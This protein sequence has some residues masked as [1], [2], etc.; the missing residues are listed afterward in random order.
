MS[1]STLTIRYRGWA[2]VRL[3]TDPDPADE[4]YG[5]SG[6]TYAYAGEP[7]L[8]RITRFQPAPQF[9]RPGPGYGEHERWPWGVEVFDAFTLANGQK[10][11][12]T[13][14]IGEPVDMLDDPVLENRNWLLT[15]PGWEP[16]VPF[17]LRIGAGEQ[18]IE[19]DAPIVKGDDRPAWQLPTRLL[20]TQAARGV[21][22][23]R[24]AI[25]TATGIWD[26][27]Q[28]Y[29]D[30][31]AWLEQAIARETDPLKRQVLCSRKRQVETDLANPAEAIGTHYAI[32]SFDFPVNGDEAVIPASGQL[33][34][35]DR[36]APW[37]VSFFFGCFDADLLGAF[38]QGAL[39]IPFRNEG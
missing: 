20:M 3:P 27:V 2:I 39:I 34:T 1:R 26:A 22:L 29:E 12:V 17:K 18:R 14:L 32:E 38:V 9:I 33:S 6:Y 11:T 10:T 13:E 23:D 19:R 4:P 7:P 28:L 35:L 25:G 37:F 8:D 30:R 21:Y 36:S 24:E 15:A 31:R 5:V 16:F